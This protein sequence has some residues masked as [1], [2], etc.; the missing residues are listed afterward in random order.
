VKCYGISQDPVTKNYVM[1]ME[2]IKDGNLRQFLNSKKLSFINRLNLLKNLAF[3]LELIHEQDLVHKDFHSGNIL[4]I[5][6]SEYCTDSYIADLGLSRP[7][8]ETN[9]EKIY[10]V[11][12]YLAPEVLREKKY[13]KTSDIY[14]FGI[15]AYEIFSNSP[16]FREYDHDT[17]L[18]ERICD[19]LRPQFEIE[20]PQLLKDLIESC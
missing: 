4:N 18:A 10:G 6:R 14:S 13:T 5:F 16:P 12:P 9:D 8:N 3:G 19:G 7:A 2:Y 15:I 11:L 20:L 1:V 17:A